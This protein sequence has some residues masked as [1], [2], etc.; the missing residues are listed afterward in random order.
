MTH[1]NANTFPFLAR[2]CTIDVIDGAKRSLDVLL[3]SL[4]EGTRIGEALAAKPG[5]H[6]VVARS[7]MLPGSME[8]VVIPTLEAAS[9]KRAITEELIGKK[10]RCFLNAP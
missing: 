3:P 6:M 10:L 7:T 5:Y 4:P 8:S 2:A 1:G 9:G